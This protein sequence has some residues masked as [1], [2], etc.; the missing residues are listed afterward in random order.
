MIDSEDVDHPLL[1]SSQYEYGVDHTIS[2]KGEAALLPPEHEISD[3]SVEVAAIFAHDAFDGVTRESAPEAGRPRWW[4]CRVYLSIRP[5]VGPAVVLLWL[6]PFFEVSHPACLSG[7]A[8]C[9]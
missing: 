4:Y 8:C 7:T 2:V 9:C 1:T 3:E 6:L 5:W